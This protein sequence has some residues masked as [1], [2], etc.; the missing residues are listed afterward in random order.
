[1]K[2]LPIGKPA[3]GNGSPGADTAILARGLALEYPGR[4]V[5]REVELQVRK[6]EFWYFVGP[7]G[8]GKS[9]LL[10]AILG[11]ISPSQGSLELAPSLT[12]HRKIGFVPQRC[13][14]KPTLPMT[15]SEFVL[16]GL[17]GTRIS[18]REARANLAWALEK[19]GL[20]EKADQDYWSLSGGQRQRALVARGLVRRPD[21]LIL[22]E[23]TNGLDIAAEETLVRLVV[24]LNHDTGV[25]VIFVTHVIGLPL[26]FGTHTALFH[27]GSI[28]S[29]RREEVL[30]D[31]L[32]GE[33]YGTEIRL[34]QLPQVGVVIGSS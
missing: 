27:G 2:G 31:S 9:T 25:T 18:R 28:T 30:T 3:G 20:P 19:V 15:V 10:R 5:L 29:G 16:L 17:A 21:L 22:D 14:L 7:N 24:S 12:S 13:D 33:A 1:V 32:L 4:P 11:S 26:R 23:P 6:G 34:S 8:S